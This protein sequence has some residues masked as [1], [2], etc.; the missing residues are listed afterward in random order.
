MNA[1]IIG[2]GGVG[3]YFGGKLTQLL[4][5]TA[6]DRL[7]IFF[8]AR[9]QHLEAIRR[10]GLLLSTVDEGDMVCRPTLATDDLEDLPELDLCLLCVKAYDLD[11]ALE[12]LK[13]KITQG[14]IVIPLLNGVDIYERI[15]KHIPQGIVYPSCVYVGTHIECYGKVAQNGG[16]CTILLGEDPQHPGLVP[17]TVLAL[18]DAARI[19]YQWHQDPYPEIWRKYIFIASYGMVTASENAPIGHVLENQELRERVI[20]IMNE[21]TDVARKKGVVLP[22]YVVEASF[23]QGGNFPYETKTSFQRDFEQAEKP[24]ESMLYGDTIISMGNA[25][26]VATPVTRLVKAKLDHIKEAHSDNTR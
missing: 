16:S 2:V 1:G 13:S 19:K 8:V 5:T 22:D 10:N 7:R 11:T 12:R 25:M 24:N 14:T 26:G 6:H 3:G 17:K 23:N 21:I 20:G 18:F 15:R 9:N 4:G